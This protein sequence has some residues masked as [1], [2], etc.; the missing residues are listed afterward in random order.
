MRSTTLLEFTNDDYLE[1]YV[2]TYSEPMKKDLVE[3]F[4]QRNIQEALDNNDIQYL[5]DE[6]QESLV[7]SPKELTT[8]LLL[9][10]I[11]ILKIATRVPRKMFFELDVVK[12]EIPKNILTIGDRAFFGCA[13]LLRVKLPK[14]IKEIGNYAFYRCT[15]LYEIEY[16]GTMEDWNKIRTGEFWHSGR[17]LYIKCSDGEIKLEDPE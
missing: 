12:V 8:I 2:S 11:D 7:W 6:F 9:S 13:E 3:F 15:D 5:Y 10:G 16:E 14:S 1:D 4:S 17:S